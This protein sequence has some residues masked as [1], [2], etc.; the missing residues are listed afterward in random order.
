M[1]R[2]L[3][4]LGEGRRRTGVAASLLLLCGVLVLSACGGSSSAKTS[5]PKMLPVLEQAQKALK[6]ATA[7]FS[8]V[9]TPKVNTNLTGGGNY[10]TTAT[11]QRAIVN[12]TQNGSPETSTTIVDNIKTE[13]IQ[14]ITAPV[15]GVSQ[16]LWLKTSQSNVVVDAVAGVLYYAGYTNATQAADTTIN[17][18]AVYHIHG[19]EASGYVVDLYL[20][21]DNFLPVK[22][23]I[24]STKETVTTTTV[25]YTKVN[26]GVKID[27]PPA[28][29]IEG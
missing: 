24:P 6:D 3:G 5:A 2:L 29:Q 26:S 22:A 14:T 11:P 13:Y 8:F 28:D 18:V 17:G 27:L 20:R 23:V 15:N 7:T 9:F 19:T 10:K 1:S 16:T 25:T 21:K 4:M 12:M